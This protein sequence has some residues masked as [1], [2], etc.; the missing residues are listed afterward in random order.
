[1]FFVL[2]LNAAFVL[3][4]AQCS[5][6]SQQCFPPVVPP[7]PTSLRPVPPISLSFASASTRQRSQLI[8]SVK[9]HLGPHWHRH[10]CENNKNIIIAD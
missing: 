8:Q 2:S 1:M 3:N 9:F 10:N 5:H 6:F 4:Q 7:P